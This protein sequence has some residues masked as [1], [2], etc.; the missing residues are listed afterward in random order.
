MKSIKY[1]AIAA[2]I[3]VTA[4]GCKKSG[5]KNDL[6]NNFNQQALLTNIGNNILVPGINNFSKS[7]VTTQ[8]AIDS[9][10][11][12]PNST[13]LASAQDSFMQLSINWAVVEPFNFGPMTDNLWAPEIDTWPIDTGKIQTAISSLANASAQGGDSKGLK[14]LEYLLF[15]VNGNQ[16]VLAKY[17]GPS[18]AN[19]K[20]Y[21]SSVMGQITLVAAALQT[22]WTGNGNYINTFITATGNSVSSSVSLLINSTA[23]YLDE[24]K[25]AK[26]GSPIGMGV[27]VNDNQPHPNLIEYPIAELSIPAMK[28]NIQSMQS[29]FDGGGAGTGLRDLLNFVGAVQNGQNL[30]TVVDTEFVSA[31]NEVNGITPP[32]AAA[33]VNQTQQLKNLYTA[34]KLLVANY[35]V[36]V[37]NNLGVAITFADTDGD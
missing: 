25:N 23:F 5:S 29:V 27:R 35:K 22:A 26:V 1:P 24:V 3:L 33:T 13:T 36:N 7:S 15:D 37:S 2:I 8:T 19:M 21:L 18:A 16:A 4:S 20:S 9:F 14:A 31:I 10:I 6:F 34:L 11:A 17:T 12:N 30:S 28:A 32:Y